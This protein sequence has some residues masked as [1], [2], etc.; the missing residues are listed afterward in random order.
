MA[1]INEIVTKA[2]RLVE[3]KSDIDK[4]KKEQS[5]IEG[6]FLKLS[7][8]DLKDTKLKTVSYFG[9]GK[10]KVIAT[11]AESLKVTYP[12]FLKKIFGDAYKD[13]ITE[14]TT[15]KLSASAKR[16]LTGLWLKNYT[17]ST[18]GEVISQLPISEE[19]KVTVA[20]KVRGI[21]YETDKK[22]LISLCGFD[23]DSASDYA[24]LIN[25]AA[26]WENFLKLMKI[27][28]KNLN[29]DLSEILTLIDGAVVVEET[30][31]IKIESV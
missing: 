1:L 11:M 9:T 20:K 22:N 27:N 29:E 13:V 24:Y 26:V 4:L 19:I 28:D 10:N 6:F 25:E 14:E 21:N 7:D 30:P 23:E 16:M 2:D 3:I 17:K 18:V 12:S 8:Q 15:Y 31:K 5:E